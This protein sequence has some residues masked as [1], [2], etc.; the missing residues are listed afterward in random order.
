MRTWAR[1]WVLFT[2]V[3][4]AL[5]GLVSWAIAS[6]LDVGFAHLPVDNSFFPRTDA[7]LR[8]LDVAAQLRRDGSLD[9]SQRVVFADDAGGD[10][11]LPEGVRGLRVDGRPEQGVSQ[12]GALK[13]AIAQKKATVEYRL[14]ELVTGYT[15]VAV[16][17]WP[18]L[19]E[20][21]G[22]NVNDSTVKLKGA[23]VL[24]G[25]PTKVDA[26]LRTSLDPH[27]KLKGRTL[28]FGAKAPPDRGASLEAALPRGLFTA[29]PPVHVEPFAGKPAF[30]QRQRTLDPVNRTVERVRSTQEE[31]R[32]IVNLVIL[33]V[34]FTGPALLWPFVLLGAIRLRWK[35]YRETPKDVPEY[36]HE[37]PSDDDPAVVAALWS[38]GKLRPSA[39]AGTVLSLAQRKAVTIDETGPGKFTLS[40]ND[41]GAGG[42]RGE[43]VVLGG[44]YAA[45]GPDGKID[46]PPLWR[47]K[48]G[49]WRA[50]RR[51]AIARGIS[52]GLMVYLFRRTP[53][54]LA[55]IFTG[56]GIGVFFFLSR[57]QLFMLVLMGSVF[58]G[59]TL[60]FVGGIELT[61][62][63]RRLRAH[64]GAY[65]KQIKDFTE[66]EH[67]PPATVAL[68][69]PFLTYGAVLGVATET[70]EALSPEV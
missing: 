38:R 42:T 3:M 8:K 13:V 32:R 16:L 40:V 68:W 6:R 35:R 21:P 58:L 9:L 27:V 22:A 53:L 41:A 61:T 65:G 57:P 37:P 49:W 39:V 14:E 64:W 4:I 51:D 63:G 55:S 29:L 26:G 70:A 47:G 23:L 34:A 31:A 20:D 2:V 62:E 43:Q 36:E 60:S 28:R 59:L 46:A 66:V 45:A 56:I 10:L 12:E 30:D 50:Y 5:P 18:I 24:P 52:R 48:A 25:A 44:L 15:D 11:F 7:S 19:V 17:E 69:G 54:F 67:A 1:F 33:V